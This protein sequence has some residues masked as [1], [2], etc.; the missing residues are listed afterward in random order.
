[1]LLE[2]RD[3]DHPRRGELLE[4]LARTYWKPVYHYVRALRRV[5][6]TDAEDLTQQFF[7]T[8]LARGDLDRLAPERGS[9]RGFLKTALRNFLTSADRS[10][11]ARRRLFTFEPVDEGWIAEAP[12]GP[13][14]IFDR[15]WGQ[16]VLAE[17]VE[18]LRAE[19]VEKGKAVHFEI[20][21]AY[22]LREE[23]VT[24]EA[25]ARRHGLKADDVRNR[26]RE[27]RA[28]LRE[29]VRRLLREYLGPDESVDDEL[30]FIL[31]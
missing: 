13:D 18:R 24:Y 30:A 26:L 4:G 11:A 9:F 3:P 7:A 1:M 23:P 10:A 22:C 6:P 17:A 12:L 5:G 19:L 15:A 16:A 2:L 27:V 21:E 31:R 14:E 28:R 25:L 20:F 29:I 8:L